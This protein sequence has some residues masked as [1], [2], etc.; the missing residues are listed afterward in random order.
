MENREDHIDTNDYCPQGNTPQ[1]HPMCRCRIM[2]FMPDV[3]KKLIDEY[4]I[5]CKENLIWIN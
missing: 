4:N 3:T 2:V 1:D 5:E